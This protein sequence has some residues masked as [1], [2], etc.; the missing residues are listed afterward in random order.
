ML[1]AW[2][3]KL[4]AWWFARIL[5]RMNDR[6]RPVPSFTGKLNVFWNISLPFRGE[7][8]TFWAAPASG[9]ADGDGPCGGRWVEV[10]GGVCHVTSEWFEV[11]ELSVGGLSDE[12]VYTSPGQIFYHPH[13][14]CSLSR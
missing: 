8:E 14:P 7:L 6:L 10:L 3:S 1:H 9:W 12:F 13:Q 11:L 2:M 4:G 5:Q